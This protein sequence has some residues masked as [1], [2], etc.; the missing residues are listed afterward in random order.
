MHS[1]VFNGS[2]QPLFCSLKLQGIF[3]QGAF[4]SENEARHVPTNGDDFPACY[5]G[6]DSV[7]NVPSDHLD[8]F[9]SR[10]LPLGKLEVLL[11]HLWFAGAEHP[12]SPLHHQIALG[13]EIVIT[14]RMDL[15]LL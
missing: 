2:L 7:V 15:Y 8:D 12:A 10:D 9:L 5:R 1:N 14:E 6:S 13:R 11:K 3:H 4:C